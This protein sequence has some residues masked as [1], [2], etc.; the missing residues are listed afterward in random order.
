MEYKSVLIIII[1]IMFI[2]C[3]MAPKSYDSFSHRESDFDETN[4]TI[5]ERG[6]TQEQINS[7]LATRF[8][9]NNKVSIA[10]IFLQRFYTRSVNNNGL[11][12]YIMSQGKNINNVEKY[13]PIPRIFIP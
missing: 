13:V 4:I 8:P 5:S 6:L 2:G 1:S 3:A 7:I 11:P 12:Y 10:V 9:P